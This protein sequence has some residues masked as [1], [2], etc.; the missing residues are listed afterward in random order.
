MCLTVYRLEEKLAELFEK[1]HYTH[2]VKERNIALIKCLTLQSELLNLDF[3]AAK[4]TP[5]KG[6]KTKVKTENAVITIESIILNKIFDSGYIR[7][8]LNYNEYD[9]IFYYSKERFEILMDWM[10]TL[11]NLTFT[12]KLF[13]SD[14]GL[15]K[16]MLK[17]DKAN[18]IRKLI[19][20]HIK[21]SFDFFIKLKIAS[22]EAGYKVEDLIKSFEAKKL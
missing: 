7:D 10:F 14:S 6:K 15:D 1:W 17:K 13:A 21:K 2:D 19:V 16:K 4:K 3:D 22:D 18:D 11:N 5:V 9:G 8:Y 12:K 20:S